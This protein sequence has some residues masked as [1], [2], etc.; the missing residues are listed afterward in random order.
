MAIT[1]GG[2]GLWDQAG[3]ELSNSRAVGVGLQEEDRSKE[4]R[5][6]K[7]ESEKR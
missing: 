7:E 1:P 5:R 4:P 6:R 3:E 2:N